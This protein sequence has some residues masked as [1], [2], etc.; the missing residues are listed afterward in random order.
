MMNQLCR[1]SV[2]FFIL[3]ACP[4][5]SQA[6]DTAELDA[7]IDNEFKWLQEEAG[8]NF[9]TVATKTEITAQEAPAIVSVISAKEI[10]NMGARDIIDV[11]RTVPGF[12]MCQNNGLPLHGIVIRGIQSPSANDKTRIMINGHSMQAFW[13][14]PQQHFD[15]LPIASIKKIEIIRGPGS[16]LYGTG[17]FSGVINIITKQ[18]GDEPSRV[19]F[20]RG[21]FNTIKP[22][23]ELSYKNDDFKAYLYADYHKTDGYDGTVESDAAI[24]SPVIPGFGPAILPSVSREMNS[25]STHHTIQANI[26][27]KDIYFSGFFQKADSNV[28]IGVTG[29][30]TD[31]DDFETFYAYGELGFKFP[32]TDRGSLLAKIYYDH[33]EQE[34]VYELFPEETA[35]LYGFPDGEGIRGGPFVNRSVLGGEIT[36]EHN[37][38]PG[39]QLVAGASYEYIKQFDVRNY[40]N[41]NVTG[42]DINVGGI[43]YPFFPYQYFPTGITDISE[44]ANWNKNEDRGIGAVYA[45]GILD[46]K[47]LFSMEKGVYNLSLTTG[48]RYD[49]YDDV[50]STTN[51]RFGLVYAPS[52][53]LYFKALYGKAFRAPNFLELYMQNNPVGDGNPYLKPEKISTAEALIGY[54]FSKNIR[55]T[56]TFFNIKSDDLIQFSGTEG[57]YVNVGE[58]ESNGFEAELKANFGK[59]KYAYCNFTWQDVKNTTNE[60]I[61]GTDER[62]ED[63]NPGNIPEFYGNIGVNYDFFD[64]H[65][66]A[67]ISLNY[68]G[69]RERSE[70]KM[71]NGEE[72][73]QADPRDPVKARTLFNAS[74]TFRNF[75]NRLKGLE[76][77]VSG[78]NLFNEDHRDPN[79][80]ESLFND[81]P[82]PGRTFT[83]RISYS[84]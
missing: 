82:R 64:E 42:S 77:Q 33:A 32:T 53:K 83:G 61:Q 78:F 84:F 29:I 62:Q 55:S 41:C 67:N 37:I 60:E 65:V 39:I 70:E 7:D 21:T 50:G 18:G 56:I 12:D 46:I 24:N 35:Q 81:I 49:H 28:P 4:V 23:S 48:L 69:E 73:V 27:Y 5:L 47:K 30:L 3:L 11:L 17:A 6:T 74:L 66:I 40:A 19:S 75:I 10:R 76:I 2:I 8:V 36:A 1:L 68:V 25:E 54:H 44:S 43:P 16:A 14:D 38:Y 63:F 13:G 9:V 45:Q 58:M 31:E 59:F 79:G 20:E 15:R 51:P 26:S 57:G 80:R 71:W 22:Y 34:T 72:T 52:E